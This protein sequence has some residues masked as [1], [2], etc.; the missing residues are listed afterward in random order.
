[1]YKNIKVSVIVVAAGKGTRM[2]S[3]VPKQYLKLAGKT[4]LDSTLYKFERSNYIDEII[5]VVNKEEIDYVKNNFADKYEKITHVVAGGAVR[6]ES[7]YEGI[8]NTDDDCG[9]LLIHDGV[10]PFISYKL[11]NE[12]VENAYEYKA[13]VPV[14]D[15][16]D[17]IKEVTKDRF[18]NKTLDRKTLKSIQTPQAFQFSLIKECYI[19]A[20]CEG[21]SFTDDASVVEHYGYKVKA[22]DGLSKNIKITT[23]FDFKIAEILASIY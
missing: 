4:I 12:C 1:M 15:V 17:T 13:C 21:V 19:Q 16:S 2:K 23:P 7:V 11:I 9:I 22:I 14:L 3:D 6:T 20:V 18:V 10:R 8:K 5:L